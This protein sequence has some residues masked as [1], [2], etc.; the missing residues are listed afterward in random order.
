MDWQILIN[1]GATVVLGTVGWFVRGNVA[2]QKETS[3]ELT[4]LRIKVAQDYVT[5][6]AL[7]DIKHTLIR[8]ENK[9]D[10]K[11]DK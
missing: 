4:A 9:I 1:I 10:Q 11:A 8:I 7:S 5:H 2:E 3:R 6:S